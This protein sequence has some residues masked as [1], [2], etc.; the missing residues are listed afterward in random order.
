MNDPK[1]TRRDGAMHVY[2]HASVSRTTKGRLG[3]CTWSV[4][5]KDFQSRGF[6]SRRATPWIDAIPSKNLKHFGVEKVD[7]IRLG[8]RKSER[9]IFEGMRSGG[10]GGRRRSGSSSGRRSK[11]NDELRSILR[12]SGCEMT[13][14]KSVATAIIVPRDQPADDCIRHWR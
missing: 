4:G 2:Y 8:F 14:L 6:A 9:D 1:F 11:A 5:R 13:E 7:A 10:G 3:G 12:S